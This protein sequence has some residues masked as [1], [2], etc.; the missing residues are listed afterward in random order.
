[1]KRVW[2]SIAA[3]I[4]VVGAGVYW[5]R[6]I[7]VRQAFAPTQQIAQPGATVPPVSPLGSPA[8]IAENSL[9]S[10]ETVAQDLEIPWEVAW[11]PTGEMLVTERPGRLL[12]IGTDKSVIAIAG[13]AHVGEGG[14]QGLALHPK[15]AENQWLYLYLT[16]QQDAG[17]T[18]RVERYRLVG[19]ELQEKTTIIDGIPGA[20]FHDGGR[21][22]FGPDG[23]LYITTGDAGAPEAAQDTKS[24]AGKILR[25]RDDGT[26]P[27]DNPF[28]NAVYSYGHRNPQGLAWDG[29]GRL[30][31]TEHGRSGIT[32]GFDEI[33]LIVAGGNYGW[34]D[35]EGDTVQADTRAPV[36]H[37]GSTV[38]WAPAGAA[39][40]GDRLI[41][42]GLRGEALYSLRL[43]GE[44]VT[45]LTAHFAGEWG[46][47][48]ATLVGPDGYLYVTTSNTDGR[49]TKRPGDDKVIR[50]NPEILLP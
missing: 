16:T 27:A 50:I 37:S 14:L 49:G 48:R 13:V 15:F 29:A 24:L 20:Q 23:L 32:S 17:L 19:A 6:D 30:W 44:T 4:V 42:S 10:V 25:V 34:P 39:V 45:D 33:N 7:F 11:L 1:M 5:W 28:G 46:R 12:K 26:P 43:V 35:S 9:L 40:V 22:A 31:A 21:I 38:T 41:F 18:N 2:L 3:L 47:L 8:A 36:L